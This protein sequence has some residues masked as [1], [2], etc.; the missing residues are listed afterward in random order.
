AV[1]ATTLSLV[2]VFVPV[3]FMPGIVGQFFRQFGITISVAVLISLFISFTLDP[4]MSARLAK[5]RV[6]G[7]AR[8]ENAV[9]AALR[10]FLDGTE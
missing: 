6:P 5:R 7:E 1:L 9:A 10:R 4:M 3:A 8:K 2:A